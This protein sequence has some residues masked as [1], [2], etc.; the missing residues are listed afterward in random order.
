MPGRERGELR[1]KL[2]VRD[3][4]QFASAVTTQL[5]MHSV[6]DM[7]GKTVTCGDTGLK[8]PLVESLVE[9]RH[10]HGQVWAPVLELGQGVVHVGVVLGVEPVVVGLVTDA[11]LAP[12]EETEDAISAELVARHGSVP[13]EAILEDK[14]RP[15]QRGGLLEVRHRF[16]VPRLV[17]VTCTAAQHTTNALSIRL[18]LQ[19]DAGSGRLT[20]YRICWYS[21]ATHPAAKQGQHTVR[22][23]KKAQQQPRGLQIGMRR[24]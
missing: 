1:L 16:G 13:V 11:V 12:Q 4:D 5:C 9:D 14:L 18:P 24:R 8:P 6:L 17:N 3:V 2:Y 7:Y 22:R 10:R 15:Y 20:C 23:C 19:R 21:E